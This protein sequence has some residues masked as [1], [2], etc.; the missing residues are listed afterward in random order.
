L[1]L[2]FLLFVSNHIPVYDDIVVEPVISNRLRQLLD[3]YGAPANGEHAVAVVSKDGAR[4]IALA[5]S[6]DDYFTPCAIVMPGTL[7]QFKMKNG[8]QFDVGLSRSGLVP[9]VTPARYGFI[10][11]PYCDNRVEQALTDWLYEGD[12]CAGTFQLACNVFNWKPYT[13]VALPKAHVVKESSLNDLCT[14]LDERSRRLLTER[15]TP[16]SK[17]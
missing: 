1:P 12:V 5:S 4:S 10:V 15:V 6:M 16:A 7:Y 14:R 13:P 17:G 3:T 9:A 11:A 2:L 8:Q